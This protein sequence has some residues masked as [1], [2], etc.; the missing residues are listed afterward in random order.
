M[1][2]R[3]RVLKTFLGEAAARCAVGRVTVLGDRQRYGDCSVCGGGGDA[4]FPGSRVDRSP[5]TSQNK[6]LKGRMLTIEA[7]QPSD[8][9]QRYA[10]EPRGRHGSIESFGSWLVMKNSAGQ[11]A[12]VS[13]DRCNMGRA[14][15]LCRSA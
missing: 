9:T 15:R 11:V 12:S 2:V 8:S 3:E 14:A 6:P 1:A 5:L 10:R 13:R 7:P 4:P